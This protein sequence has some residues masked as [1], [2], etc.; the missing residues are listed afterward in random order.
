MFRTSASSNRLKLR[1]HLIQAKLIEISVFTI[2]AIICLFCHVLE[3]ALRRRAAGEEEEEVEEEEEIVF[4]ALSDLAESSERSRRRSQPGYGLSFLFALILC[5]VNTSFS[6]LAYTIDDDAPQHTSISAKMAKRSPYGILA[7]LRDARLALVLMASI[8]LNLTSAVAVR[9]FTFACG[10]V[11]GFR[12][13]LALAVLVFAPFFVMKFARNDIYRWHLTDFRFGAVFAV[14]TNLVLLGF[15]NFTGHL[16]SRHPHTLG[17]MFFTCSSLFSLVLMYAAGSVLAAEVERAGDDVTGMA[18][19]FIKEGHLVQAMTTLSLTFVVS[20]VVMLLSL[21]P[22]ARGSFF[23][24]ESAAAATRLF[25]LKGETDEQKSFILH[26]NPAQWRSIREE[27]KSWVLENFERWEEEKPE[28][29]DLKFRKRVPVDMLPPSHARKLQEVA[30]EKESCLSAIFGGFLPS[31]YNAGE[32]AC[33]GSATQLEGVGSRSSEE[34]I[35]QKVCS[36]GFQREAKVY[37]KE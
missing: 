25:Y 1:V 15:F 34:R 19:D 16:A 17:G 9:T 3:R 12:G 4:S 18:A 24:T 29:F 36:W 6:L 20:F 33:K 5:T 14:V 31:I 7:H 37:A 35:E 8:L 30:A 21:T 2:P 11:F 23:S 28:W 26:F 32:P 27:V 22:E 13:V 10:I